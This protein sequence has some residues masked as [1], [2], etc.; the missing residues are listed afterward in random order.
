MQCI[1]KGQ[2]LREFFV[3][4]PNDDG[5]RRTIA[6]NAERTPP[7]LSLGQVDR[8]ERFRERFRITST[9][10][11]EPWRRQADE[12][13]HV[14]LLNNVLNLG[15]ILA[16][17]RNHQRIRLSLCAGAHPFLTLHQHRRRRFTSISAGAVGLR[18]TILVPIAILSPP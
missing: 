12:I 17:R 10:R 18:L 2:D 1:R 14:E 6:H 16:V 3:V 8:S 15:E 13:S 11:N 9:D 7:V 4:G 5:V